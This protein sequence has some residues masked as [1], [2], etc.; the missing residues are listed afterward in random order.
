MRP[1]MILADAGGNEI[2]LYGGIV[3]RSIGYIAA[4][5]HDTFGAGTEARDY[6]WNIIT[7][8]YGEDYVPSA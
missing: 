1:Y 7:H 5:N 8:V 4:Q 6:V 3:E 2:T